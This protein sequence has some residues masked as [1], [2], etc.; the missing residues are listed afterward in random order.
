MDF[1]IIENSPNLDGSETLPTFEVYLDG[2]VVFFA[3]TKTE[4]E[5]WISQQP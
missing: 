2:E 4:C 3:P 1:N 5:D